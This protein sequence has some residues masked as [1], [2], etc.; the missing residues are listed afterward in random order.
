MTMRARDK[1][2]TCMRPF[3][4]KGL[5]GVDPENPILVESRPVR[6]ENSFLTLR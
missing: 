1:R 2:V 3:V 4:L 5:E 6:P